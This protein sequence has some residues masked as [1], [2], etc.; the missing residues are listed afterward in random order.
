MVRLFLKSLEYII[1]A[2]DIDVVFL[3]YISPSMKL[4]FLCFACAHVNLSF[5]ILGFH[6]PGIDS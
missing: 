1:Y 4:G 2:V 3:A 5:H 6:V